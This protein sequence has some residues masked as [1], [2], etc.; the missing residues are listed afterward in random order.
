MLLAGT[1][2]AEPRIADIGRIT[3]DTDR[4]RLEGDIEVEGDLVG[5]WEL[6]VRKV[7]ATPDALI[8]VGTMTGKLETGSAVLKETIEN[9]RV[10]LS[11]PEAVCGE[12]V[13]SADELRFD[14]LGLVV[15]D[16]ERE[17]D[18]SA[19]TPRGRA[20]GSL[21]CAVNHLVDAEDP[22]L[23]TAIAQTAQLANHALAQIAPPPGARRHNAVAGQP[24][25][26]DE[27]QADPAFAH[28]AAPAV[29]PAAAH[30]A[31]PR[32]VNVPAASDEAPVTTP[33][34]APIRA[35]PAPATAKKHALPQLPPS[36]ALP[37]AAVDQDEE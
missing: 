20:L 8:V 5:E 14:R 37:A 26:T 21:L 23:A 15:Y 16:L 18:V 29:H 25:A 2:R 34:A 10:E 9:V 7:E 13:A 31:A 33:A 22:A 17:A 28:P 3:I 1:A 24:P 11:D 6:V 12:L 35:W 30:A 4:A 36:Q 19:K 27:G 32:V